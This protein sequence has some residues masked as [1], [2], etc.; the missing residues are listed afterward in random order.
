MHK[1][2]KR[3]LRFSASPRIRSAG[4]YKKVTFIRPPQSAINNHQ[5]QNFH[6]SLLSA[7]SLFSTI[8]FD[9]FS[10]Q[11][12]NAAPDIQVFLFAI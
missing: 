10:I 1:P 9:F 12:T 11:G 5:S 3:R 4:D 2:K 6:F 8:L 7:L